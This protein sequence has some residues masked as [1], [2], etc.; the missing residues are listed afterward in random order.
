APL[1]RAALHF[2]NAGRS[3]SVA[4]SDI[5]AK[6]VATM[7][8]LGSE[9]LTRKQ[10]QAAIADW[11]APKLAAESKTAEDMAACMQ[12]FVNHGDSLGQAIRYAEHLFA[13]AGSVH[14][15]TG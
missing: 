1:L 8:K 3:V 12:V 7:R 10:A 11:L 6:L 14:F 5:G 2:L 13:Q 4:G 9:E 15:T